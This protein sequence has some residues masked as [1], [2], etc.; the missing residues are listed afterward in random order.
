MPSDPE[1][2]LSRLSQLVNVVKIRIVNFHNDVCFFVSPS[3]KET[4]NI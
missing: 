4:K 2:F 1:I 3:F